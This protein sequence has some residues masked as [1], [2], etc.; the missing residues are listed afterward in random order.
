MVEAVVGEARAGGPRAISGDAALKAAA[1][2]WVLVTLL[3]QWAFLYYIAAFYGAATLSGNFQAWSRNTVLFKGYVA[4]DMAG[5]LVFGA[6]VLL[7]AVVALGGTVQLLPQIRRR[8]IAFHRWNGRVFLTTAM[9]AAIA[10]LY[11]VWVRGASAN[12]LGALAI[13]LDA[14]LILVFAAQAWRTARGRNVTDHRRWAMRAFLA[15]N[16]VWFYRVGFMAWI[17]INR[18]PVGSTSHL[19]GPFDIFWEFG[20]YLVPLGVLEL[21]LRTTGGSGQHARMA[22]AGGL[23]ASSILTAIGCVAAYVI[24]WKPL[25]G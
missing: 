24:M 11:M 10:G 23:L 16:G 12:L 18:G 25:L 15:A 8:A 17:A 5:N 21:Y 13:S 9:V 19:D 14:A 4:G 3:G 6:H 20:S 2:L 1:G 22:M 7:A